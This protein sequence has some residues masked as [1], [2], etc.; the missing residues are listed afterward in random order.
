MIT[1]VPHSVTKDSLKLLARS[2]STIA[3]IDYPE[4]QGLETDTLSN[5]KPV[6]RA[7]S[8]SAACQTVGGMQYGISMHGDSYDVMIDHVISHLERMLKVVPRDLPVSLYLNWPECIDGDRVR[9]TMVWALGKPTKIVFPFDK[10]IVVQEPAV[11]Q[12]KLWIITL[13][14]Y[15]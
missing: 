8:F 5:S 4:K 10:L 13:T 12:S 7:A 9:R 2:H 15:L 11:I 6:F 1:W 3:T 14:F